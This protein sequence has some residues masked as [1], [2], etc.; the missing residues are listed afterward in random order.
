VSGEQNRLSV[1]RLLR[2]RKHQQEKK[3][4]ARKLHGLSP[5]FAIFPATSRDTVISSE[6]ARFSVACSSKQ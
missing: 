4:R 6:I 5:I 1:F 3:T 2:G